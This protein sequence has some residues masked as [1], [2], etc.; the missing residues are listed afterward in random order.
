MTDKPKR[1]VVIAGGGT[2]GWM[3]AA[4][5]ARALGRIVD[6]TLVESE[7][8]GTV[9]VGEATI[10][11]I[12]LFNNVLG[13]DENEFLKATNGTMK[14]GIEFDGWSAPGQHYMHAFGG[15]GMSLGMTTFHQYWLRAQKNWGEGEGR[16]DDLWR[17]SLNARAAYQNRF[18]RLD[19]VGDTPLQ[20]LA[21]AFHF[22]AALYTKY[23]HQYTEHLGVLHKEGKIVDVP[24][25]EGGNIS[26]IRLDSGEEI[27][28]DLFIDCTG[29]RALLIGQALGADYVDW[30][31]WLPC[32]RAVAVPSAPLPDL[33][34]YTR[35][36]AQ[37]AGWQWR[38]P[39]QHRTGNG[40]VYCSEYLSDDEAAAT[41]LDNLET[42]AVGEPRPLAFTTGH[43]EVF[44]KGNCIALG[45]AAGFM[46]PLESTSIHLIQSGISRLI[47]IFPTERI[48]P[49][50]VAE[51]NRQTV[52]EYEHIRD[53]LILHYH[54]ND[55]KGQ[56]FWDRC[57]DMAIPE[58]LQ[59]KYDLFRH[60]G[61]FF[62]EDEE[63]FTL[64]GWVQVMI[65]QGVMPEAYHPLADGL[66]VAQLDEFRA[67]LGRII[68]QAV[69]GLPSH[70]D[71]IAQNCASLN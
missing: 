36:Q 29:F 26:A 60:A 56:P 31:R 23:L 70:K 9:G 53:F 37:K 16:G 33:P 57:R 43:R 44:W 21:Y 6:I 18:A 51:Y 61:R 25:G 54:A 62:R 58:S 38:I 71:Y 55:R 24:L 63:L 34:P 69:S 42:E 11:Q 5:L 7:A 1:R 22:D 28:G 45:L 30:R 46:E 40:H 35:A 32:D 68:G 14:L 10:P 3:A 4:A 49:A 52:E 47:N 48:A 41:L 13:L 8:I 50:D 27:T 66:S 12:K 64:D 2:A 17:Y 65:G 39:L 20:G 19:R 59:R 15:V 67:N